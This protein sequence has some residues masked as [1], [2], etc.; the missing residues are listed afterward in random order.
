MGKIIRKTNRGYWSETSLV[1]AINEIKSG[2]TLKIASEIYNIP[3]STLQRRM[4]SENL[5]ACRRGRKPSFNPDLESEI[6]SHAVAL[7]NK[8]HGLSV[9]QI[10]Q[11][12]YKC[13]EKWKLKH[14]FNKKDRKAGKD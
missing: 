10:S 6:A 1:T 12:V 5:S 11:A 2:T 13:A 4:K 7:S 14:N 3:R 8:F 9:G